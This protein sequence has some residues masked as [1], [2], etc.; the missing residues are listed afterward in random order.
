MSHVP[1]CIFRANRTP[2]SLQ[3]R[4]GNWTAADRAEFFEAT[5]GA[6]E[7]LLS[8]MGAA[9]KLPI[10]STEPLLAI[11]APRNCLW[12]RGYTLYTTSL[13]DV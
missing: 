12:A 10:L 9:A 1:T 7:L 13:L 8:T 2:F 11:R 5:L 6:L 4:C 3:C